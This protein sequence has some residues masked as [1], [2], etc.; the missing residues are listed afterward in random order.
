MMLAALCWSGVASDGEVAAKSEGDVGSGEAKGRHLGLAP[1]LG[2]LL[3][4]SVYGYGGY[5]HPYGGLP[6]GHYG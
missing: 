2:G 3:G 1:V 4:P 5:P 6:F